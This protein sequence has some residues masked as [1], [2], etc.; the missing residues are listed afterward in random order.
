MIC[1]GIIICLHCKKDKQKEVKD[2]CNSPINLPRDLT[3]STDKMFEFSD[4]GITA[5]QKEKS[6]KTAAEEDVAV[7]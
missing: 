3:V 5:P 7:S 2:Q 6:V 1:C 4:R